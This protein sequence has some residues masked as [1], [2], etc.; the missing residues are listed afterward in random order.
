MIADGHVRMRVK[1]NIAQVARR[2]AK[3]DW[4]G[5]ETVMLETSK[6]LLDL[7]HRT[8][9]YCTLATASSIDET[10]DGVQ[11]HRYL[12]FYPYIGLRQEAILLLD[13]RGGSPFS[14]SLM[15]ALRQCPD[16]DVIHLHAGNRIGG[17]GRYV[18]QKR[19]L[20]YVVSLHGGVFDVPQEAAES[21]SAPTRGTLDWGKALGWWVG[22]RRVLQDANAILCVGYPEHLLAKERMPDKR[23]I[24]LPNGVVPE[25]FVRGDGAAFRAAH[26]IPADAYV[27]ATVARI[28]AQ[29]NQLLPVRMLAELRR[30]EPKTHIL[31]VGSV[32]NAAYI[33]TIRKSIADQ[34]AQAHVTIVPGIAAASGDL[35]SAYHAADVFL[36]PSIHEPFGIV[37]L[38]AWCAGLP[39]L[40]SRVGGVPHFVDDGKDAL[41]FDPKS[42]ESFIAAFKALTAR[43]DR[44]KGLAE[45]GERKAR[46]SYTWNAITQRLVGIYEEVIREGPVRQ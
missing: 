15:R 16:L 5:A 36:L 43:E 32:T 18:A 28:D 8:E 27:V 13:K 2:F 41:L 42:P 40:A 33:E 12:Y 1:M 31:L 23:V 34:N 38:E 35:A 22:S 44:G 45:A 37:V 17:I 19:G 4:G 7:G 21:M 25:R 29:K 3:E 6:C 14:F 20:P 10:I 46:A 11:V 24:Y 30:I 39:V 26:A 9:V